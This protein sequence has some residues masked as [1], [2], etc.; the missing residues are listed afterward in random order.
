MLTN[1]SVCSRKLPYDNICVHRYYLK[2]QNLRP[3]YI[4]EW[5]TVVNWAK[6]SEY[7]EKYAAVGK[8][9]VWG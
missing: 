4:K 2:Y 5:W 3:S 1:A 9:V 7:Y 8:P 6:V